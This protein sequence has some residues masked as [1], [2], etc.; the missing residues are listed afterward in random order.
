MSFKPSN[1][2]I[3]G[4]FYIIGDGVDKVALDYQI[5]ET[6]ER[7]KQLFEEETRLRRD[8]NRSIANKIIQ[9]WPEDQIELA[10]RNEF[11]DESSSRIKNLINHWKNQFKKI[12][13]IIE[14]EMQRV[15]DGEITLDEAE[16]IIIS[17]HGTRNDIFSLF[18]RNYFAKQ[19]ENLKDDEE[20]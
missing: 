10:I 12:E 4:K 14:K 19:R 5:R 20:R 17:K 11:P 2:P 18:I 9:D 3:A 6:R 15:E 7:E 8:I 13:K 16:Q 1:K